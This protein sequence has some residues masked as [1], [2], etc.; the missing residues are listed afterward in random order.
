MKI[1]VLGLNF[2]PEKVG[3]AVYSTEMSV[4]LSLKGHDVQV[5]SGQPY[6]PGWRVHDGY[7]A[8]RYTAAD[9]NA[10]KVLRCPHY[11]PKHPSGMR[12]VLHHA[13]FALTALVPALHTA[14]TW[15]PSIVVTVAPS[16]LAAPV[17]YL[18][19]KLSGAGSWIH[20]QDFEVEAAF[21]TGLLTERSPSGRLA[22]WFER[23]VLRSFDRISSISP[24]M[25]RRL[26][27]KGVDPLSIRE[28]RNWADVSAI[29]PASS[30]SSYRSQW[31]I[32]TP[33]VALYSG[34]I[35]NKQGIEIIVEVARGLKDRDDL[36]FVICGE[37]PNRAALEQ[38]ARDLPNIQFHGLQPKEQL[39]DLLSLAT[40]HLLPQ[41]AGAE[42]LVLPSKLTNIL[43][44]GRPT[45]ATAT[46]GS[47]LTQEVEGCGLVTPPGEAGAMMQAIERL[48]A[49]KHLYHEFSLAAR[50]RAK[51]RWDREK[52]LGSFEN[53]LIALAQI[54]GRLPTNEN[55]AA[56]TNKVG[57]SDHR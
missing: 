50:E 39:H 47:G 57:D 40:I 16:L 45:V 11:I 30:P 7:S 44:S 32:G 54:K 19:A 18:A 27:Q 51:A 23:K 3:I 12:R 10:V 46:P 5:I 41:M 48:I 52:I 36:T 14:L 42:D 37:G 25:C 43:A 15:R 4:Q 53:E 1:L 49:D 17:A 26:L 56:S 55:A 35:G 31:N 29:V 2:A 13:S 6:Y 38:R 33:H 34:N 28:F 20:L 9:E 24:Q 21:A 8:W 22:M